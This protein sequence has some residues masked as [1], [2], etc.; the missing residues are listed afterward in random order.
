MARS[1]GLPL[2]LLALAVVA[3]KIPAADAAGLGG[4][5]K[6]L[7]GWSPIPDVQDDEDI[8]KLGA[9]ALAKA[10]EAHLAGDGLRFRRVVRGEQQV[11]SGMNYRLVIDAADPSGRS[12]QYV[13]VVYEQSWTNTRELTSFK[14]VSKMLGGWSPIPDV[15]SDADIQKLGAWALGKAKEAHLAGDGLRF[16]RVVRGEQQVVSGMNYRLVVDAADPSGRSAQYVAVVYEQSWTNTRELTSFKPVS[17][18][19]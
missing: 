19:P 10:K 5:G 3:L 15:Q 1:L 4:R 11:V 2:L 6:P 9:W 14:P 13:A 8:Q 16:R 7:G 18:A 17:S 12:A